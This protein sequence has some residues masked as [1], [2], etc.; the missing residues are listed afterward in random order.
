MTAAID[1]SYIEAAVVFFIIHSDGDLAFHI[2]VEVTGAKEVAD[3][4]AVN[5][6]GNVAALS[7]DQM[8]IGILQTIRFGNDINVGGVSW[9]FYSTFRAAVDVLEH[10]A[11]D[12]DIDVSKDLCTVATAVKVDRG[13]QIFATTKRCRNITKNS[14]LVGAQEVVNHRHVTASSLL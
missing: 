12:G 8:F 4:T 14:H 7:H 6:K 11:L 13:H 10:A 5:G 3:G 2:A 9:F 1:V